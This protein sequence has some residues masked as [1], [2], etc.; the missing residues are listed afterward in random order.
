MVLN[1]NNY[2]EILG[3]SFKIL[4]AG[5]KSPNEDVV[6][7]FSRLLEEIRSVQEGG[8]ALKKSGETLK[9]GVVGQVKA[10]KS[11]FLNSLFFNGE[12]VLPKA[13][14][15]MTAGLTILEHGDKDE[16]EV[17]YYNEVEWNIFKKKA[18]NL[19]ETLARVRADNP[20]VA[21]ATDEEI[22]KDLSVAE[23]DLSARE[24]VMNFNSSFANKIGKESVREKKS[25]NGVQDLQNVLEEY[26]G[27]NGKYTSIV[28]SLTIRLNDPR[29][30]K[31]CIVDTP[32]VNDPVV[33]REMCT[34]RFL[35][36]CHGVFLLSCASGSFFGATDV[37]FLVNRI[38]TEGIS[39]V[40]L[41]ASKLDSA[42]QDQ[43]VDEKYMDKFD[44][45]LEDVYTKLKE[46]FK[47]NLE[48]ANFKGEEPD[49]TMSSGI[50]FS[51]YKKDRSQWDSVEKNTVE[52]L[53][54]MY[55]S[56][57]N[58]E[59]AIKDKFKYL[60]QID[61]IC[62]EYL[63]GV[64]KENKDKIISQKVNQYFA[65]S[66]SGLTEQVKAEYDFLN[67]K[68]K[69]LKTTGIEQL[70]AMRD[71][72]ASIINEFV[73]MMGELSKQCE[74]MANQALSECLS[75]LREPSVRI[76]TYS[77]TVYSERGGTILG[78]W[79]THDVECSCRMVDVYSLADSVSRQ[80]E[81]A[82]NS[83]SRSWMRE[84][85][86][87]VREIKRLLKNKVEEAEKRCSKDCIPGADLRRVIEETVTSMTNSRE[88]DLSSIADDIAEEI[89]TVASNNQPE[90]P[91]YLGKMSEGEAK[92]VLREIAND[93]VD[94]IRSEAEDLVSDFVPRVEDELSDAKEAFVD[95]FK[96]NGSQL[97]NRIGAAM[98]ETLRN[99]ESQ[100][101]EKE[102]QIHEL[103]MAVET[104]NT[105]R[106]KMKM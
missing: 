67:E 92:S 9:I 103:E 58:S 59:E 79:N 42:L 71:N 44:Y 73:Q 72:T 60:S 68:C 41:V 31:L 12:S 105:V 77:E 6:A 65:N 63:E 40:V 50:G 85:D 37:D 51:I 101:K 75:N 34:R 2:T 46:Q 7:S 78:S 81:S 20:D 23:E 19:D 1:V 102:K 13:S 54:Q 15:P 55:P 76:P 30:D 98:Q 18:A 80:V 43:G 33:S 27:A 91:D 39:K 25:F 29:L 35:K 48:K 17:E 21:D 47:R 10:G 3:D 57:F 64:F 97:T 28:K 52:Q 26:V 100:L 22:L 53:V 5:K 8:D 93:A 86:K 62:K 87:V 104:V 38:G 90:F 32:G 4:S 14:T 84:T 16:F 94:N 66:E 11:S 88:V 89:E 99:L 70:K 61:E 45:S 96:K 24:L 106:K 82:A 74:Q 56:S 95:V 49:F 69:M 83:A 36:G